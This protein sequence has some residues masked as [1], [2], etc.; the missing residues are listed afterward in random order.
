MLCIAGARDRC[1]E[2]FHGERALRWMREGP[3]LRRLQVMSERNHTHTTLSSLLGTPVV[4][5]SGYVVGKVRELTVDAN[6]DAGHVDAIVYKLTGGAEKG[7]LRKA[8]VSAFHLRPSGTLQLRDAVGAEAYELKPQ[9]GPVEPGE[10]IPASDHTLMLGR[11]LL[12]QQII[13]VHGRKVVRANDVELAWEHED[14]GSLRLRLSEVEVGARGAIRRLLKGLPAGLVDRVAK[15]VKANSIPWGFVNLIESNPERRVKLKIEG[16]RLNKMHPSDIADILEELAPADRAALF[17]SLDDETAAETL[18]EVEPKLQKSL[19]ESLD[20]EQVADI[21]EE[22][23]PAAAADLLGE[24]TEEK[25]D[26]I[27]EEMEP[28][29]REEVQELLEYD[30]SLAGGQMTTDYISTEATATVAD[31]VRA[32]REFEGDTDPIGEIYLLDKDGKLKGMVPL[33]RL[34]LA[35]PETLLETLAE[36]NFVSCMV[37]EKA[38][39]MVE[40]FDKYNLRSLAVVD[41]QN[42]LEG[43]VHAEQVIAMLRETQ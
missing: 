13:D 33:N 26:E 23:D 14:H 10:E 42:K 25:S 41:H 18:E 24:L 34:L 38:R 16:A 27:L 22:M 1:G 28:E 36:P 37:D 29:E 19:V 32:L 3:E 2:E 15:R 17:T 5:A 9:P 21:V 4:D 31:A 7:Q 11:D 30:S 43:V 20:A 8:A 35:T 40:L 12:D 39:D 6:V